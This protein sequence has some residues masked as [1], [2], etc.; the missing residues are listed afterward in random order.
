M[1]L[2]FLEHQNKKRLLKARMA[3]EEESGSSPVQQPT[4]DHTFQDHRKLR[5]QVEQHNMMHKP[6]DASVSQGSLTSLVGGSFEGSQPSDTAQ[7]TLMPA[8]APTTPP[9][10]Q[11]V[12]QMQYGSQPGLPS[13]P[14]HLFPQGPSF[15]PATYT[16]NH[17]L[18]DYQMQLMLKE[19]QDMQRLLLARSRQGNPPPDTAPPISRAEVSPSGPHMQSTSPIQ[20]GAQIVLPSNPSRCPPYGTQV[21]HATPYGANHAFARSPNAADAQ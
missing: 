1:Q 17:A 10:I 7:A 5:E 21:Q 16:P 2:M 12:S 14:G 4:P 9:M 13:C 19:Q 3:Q 15:Y 20:Q 8:G 6:A 11:P 18:Q